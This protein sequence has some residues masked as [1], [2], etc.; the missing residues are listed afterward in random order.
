MK[1]R[2]FAAIL[3][4]AAVGGLYLAVLRPRLA[5]ARA[6]AERARESARPAVS[7][8]VARRS[9]A[10]RELV[11]PATLEALLDTP[12]R[13]RTDGYI[14]A[15]Y[16]DIGDAVKAGQVMATIA[17]PE[18]DQQ[19]S[20]ARA[21][22]LQ[23]R[24]NLALAK[25]SAARWRELGGRNAVSQ[26]EVDERMA[27]EAVRRADVAAAEANVDRLEELQGFEAIAAPFDGVVSAR[28]IDIGTLV[29]AGTG[30]ELFHLV[31]SKVLRVYVNVPQSFAPELRQGLPAEV[32]VAE[33][34]DRSFPGAVARMAG[35]LDPA[36]RT[37]LTEVEIPNPR[38]QLL[39][40][41]FCRV[42]FRARPARPPI[43]IPSDDAIVRAAGTLVAQL[44]SEGRVHFQAV[45]LGRDFGT[46][47]EVL[48]GLAEGTRVIDNPSDSLVEGQQVDPVEPKG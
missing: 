28:T 27:D 47:I 6:L 16:A 44:T 7:V 23:A 36:S 31:Q 48:D 24:A 34:P 8:T 38:R 42:R 41:M 20:Q 45:K 11:L 5:S 22:L 30:P 17:A 46:Q 26:Q 39:P 1:S 29:S 9:D 14:S 13:A 21:N 40:G 37:L 10:V 19:L 12:I 2:L 3:I 43:L 18:L 4:V 25:I 33:Y 35:A 32:L 15:W